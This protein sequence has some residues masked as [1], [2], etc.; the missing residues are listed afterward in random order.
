MNIFII[1]VL[2][3]SLAGQLESVESAKTGLEQSLADSRTALD[4][5]KEEHVSLQSMVSEHIKCGS[6]SCCVNQ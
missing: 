2:T 6:F 5:L 4:A 3:Q 1:R